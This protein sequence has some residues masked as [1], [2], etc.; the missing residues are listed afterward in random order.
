MPSRPQASVFF[1][2]TQGK[3]GMQSP[4]NFPREIFDEV[5]E[6]NRL[7]DRL[8]LMTTDPSRTGAH[9]GLIQ[10]LLA[11]EPQLQPLVGFLSDSALTCLGSNPQAYFAQ[12]ASG[13]QLFSASLESVQ[14]IESKVKSDPVRLRAYTHQDEL[15]PSIGDWSAERRKVLRNQVFLAKRHFA[16]ANDEERAQSAEMWLPLAICLLLA[17]YGVAMAG[18]MWGSDWEHRGFIM[19]GASILALVILV[20]F[21]CYAA[22]HLSLASPGGYTRL[23]S[24]KSL[25][26]PVGPPRV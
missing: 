20:A 26:L 16:I 2:E 3:P 22:Q 21:F 10:D 18:L 12:H 11:R 19:V 24:D 14:A 9:H 1:L 4:E 25:G 5:W 6:Y 8:S 17:V 23:E 15:L 7:L 13:I